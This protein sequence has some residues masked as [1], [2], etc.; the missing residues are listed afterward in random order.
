ML[1]F[2]NRSSRTPRERLFKL[3]ICSIYRTR[4]SP[5][6]HQT[7][8][9]YMDT[10]SNKLIDRRNAKHCCF[11]MAMQETSAIGKFSERDIQ[12]LPD[13]PNADGSRR[14]LHRM[15]TDACSIPLVYKMLIYSIE[16]ATSTFFSSTIVVTADQQVFLPKPAFVPMPR[17][18]MTMCGEELISIRRRSLFSVVHWVALLPCISVRATSWDIVI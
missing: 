1:Y 5:L 13:T 11:S 3:L 7:T 18:S 2:S 15:R 12:A 6:K 17:L 10:W 14:V 8:R 4:W 16:R 9:S